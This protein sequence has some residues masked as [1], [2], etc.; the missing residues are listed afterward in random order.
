MKERLERV[1][2]LKQEIEKLL[3]LAVKQG[4][5]QEEIDKL[6]DDLNFANELIRKIEQKINKKEG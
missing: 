6:L 1:L 2:V 4:A 5:S 3:N